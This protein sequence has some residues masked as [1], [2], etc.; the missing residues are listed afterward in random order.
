MSDQSGRDGLKARGRTRFAG[1]RV[2]LFI[3]LLC[4][5]ALVAGVFRCPDGSGG[6]IFQQIACTQGEAVELDVRTTEWAARPAEQP[7]P[8]KKRPAKSGSGDQA[9]LSRAAREA[10]RQEQACWRAK[11]RVEQI[12]AELRHG[13]K[14]SRG[15]RLRRQRR[16]QTDYLRAFCR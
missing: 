10:R 14:P 12:E 16:R 5:A 9:A 2:T 15:E 4:P 8:R 1:F 3:G 13:Y 11:Q 6:V 7:A